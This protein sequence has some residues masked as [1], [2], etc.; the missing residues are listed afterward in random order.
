MFN[1]LPTVKEKNPQLSK[2][3]MMR[4][5]TINLKR[6]CLAVYNGILYLNINNG[7]HIFIF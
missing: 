7:V 4:V 1:L 6:R 2:K 3:E 5:Y